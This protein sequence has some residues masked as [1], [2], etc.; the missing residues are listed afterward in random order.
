MVVKWKLLAMR[1]FI[2]NTVKLMIVNT[3]NCESVNIQLQDSV[4][5]STMDDVASY[6]L[7]ITVIEGHNNID[8]VPGAA[9]QDIRAWPSL[10]SKGLIPFEI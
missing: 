4:D 7:E 2:I 10:V 9:L 3:S 1:L 8:C 5:F 6:N